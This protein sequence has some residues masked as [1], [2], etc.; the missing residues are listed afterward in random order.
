MR[1]SWPKIKN[2]VT[3]AV[4]VAVAV[5]VVPGSILRPKLERRKHDGHRH[6]HSGGDAAVVPRLSLAGTRRTRS[7]GQVELEWKVNGTVR[8]SPN[9]SAG[10]SAS[11]RPVCY[12]SC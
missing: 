2:N 10:T 4:G 5:A 6:G 9:P 1:S 3:V 12:V 11:G 7:L 8:S